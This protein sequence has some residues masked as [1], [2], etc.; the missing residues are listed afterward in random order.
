[1]SNYVICVKVGSKTYVE[2]AD[3]VS[4]IEGLQETNL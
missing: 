2:L 4:L 1:M 3:I